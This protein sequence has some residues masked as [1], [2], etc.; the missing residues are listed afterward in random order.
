MPF[1]DYRCP[2]CGYSC[3]A[4]HSISAD[5]PDCPQCATPKPTRLITTAPAITQG[6]NANAGDGRNASKEQLRAKWAEE[7]PNLRQKLVDKL[8]EEYVSRNAPSLNPSANT[9]KKTTD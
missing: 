2:A 3:E 9:P 6:M 8:G 5:A 4:R 1:Y 7:T